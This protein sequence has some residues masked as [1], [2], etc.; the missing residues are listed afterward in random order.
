[1]EETGVPTTLAI[2]GSSVVVSVLSGAST[3]GGGTSLGATTPEISAA[4]SHV[5]TS[6]PV[7]TLPPATVTVAHTAGGV[8]PAGAGSVAS[9]SATTHGR[10]Q[11]CVYKITIILL[12]GYYIE[13]NHAWLAQ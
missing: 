6:L 5:A 7:S 8:P 9:S 3:S 2:A 10:R 12:S 1:M 4:A 11:S 13:S